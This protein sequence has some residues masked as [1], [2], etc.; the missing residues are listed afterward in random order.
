MKNKFFSIFV[1]FFI[2]Y[3]FLSCAN[4]QEQ[5]S[6]DVTEI[7]ILENG[8]KIIGSKR[9]EI[10]TNDGIVIKADTF[11]YKKNENIL[12]ANGKVIIKDT[13]NNYN[14][15]SDDITYNKNNEKISTKG[16]TKSEIYTRYIFNSND[17]TFFR[18]K[19]LINS[20]KKTTIIDNDEQTY[21]EL[22]NF[23]FSIENEILE[24]ENILVSLNYNLPQNDKLYF[25]NGIFNFKKKSFVANNI[26]I[27]LAKDIFNNLENDPRLKGVSA[28]SENNITTV[29]E[30]IFTS[31][32][33]DSDCPP[34]V[35][36]SKEIKHDKN[37]KQLI[38]KDAVLKVYNIPVLYFPKFFHPDPTVDRQ[39]G[40]LKPSF[41]NSNVL[42]SSINIP[43]YYVIS[44]NQDF[45]F[46]PTLFDD[47]VKM[48]QNEYRIKNKNSSLF[49]DFSYIDNF[50]S[51][52]T[53]KK[54]SISHIFANFDADLAWKNFTQSDLLVSIKKVSND[55]YLKIFDSNIYKN[56]VS[57]TNYDVLK[58]EAKLILNNENYN[59]TTGFQSYEDLNLSNTDR[60]Q[61][62]L[63][64][65]DFNRQ[66]FEN[67]YAGTINFSSSGSNDLNNTNN[68]RTK[69]VNDLNFQSPDF[70]SKNGFKSAYNIYFKNLNTIAKNDSIY[71]TNPQMELMSIFEL[72]TSF[73][74]I[75]QAKNS[76]T[77]FTPMASL[78]L[79]PGDM[80]DYSSSDRS[81]NVSS[82]F[83][84]NRLAIDDSFEEGKSLTLGFDYKR[85]KL[86]DINKFF[87]A[88]IA[89]VY[90]DK[91]EEFIPL[92]SGISDKDL[93][94]FGSISNNL[95]DF[96]DVSYDFIIDD[97][98]NSLKYNSL[99]TSI[100][101]KN[102]T[103]N[104]NFIEENEIIGD[105]N[106][107]ENNTTL[108]F[109]DANFLTFNTRRNKKIDLTEYYDLIYEYKNDCLI[110][111]IKY[112]K[113]YY[114]DR[115]LKPSENLL[116]S[117]TLSPL[118]SFEQKVD[119]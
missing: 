10:L 88:K 115:D 82:I 79:N 103:T 48:F 39:S 106:T 71:K 43:Y 3:F 119:Q 55:T 109:N 29:E 4:S 85:T 14:I 12:N 5:F 46:R 19:K 44:Q 28:K 77:Y 92:T 61:F 54:N 49:L 27:N 111:G 57:P 6:F 65:Y 100:A 50:K 41:N 58:S 52:L 72:N 7:E 89:T 99:K 22:K 34:W 94:I 64:Y 1:I 112:K 113:S 38:Y 24:G 84:I 56:E 9:G 53:N 68:L 102:F 105:T 15:Y 2:N 33:D 17:V 35:I 97:D 36:T 62:I 42:G 25:E 86:N 96:L 21:I 91:K 26:Q 73:P 31:C 37:K 23:N 59:F 78:R 66:I 98:L 60:Y 118:T 63:P 108:K 16:P 116:F 67:N 104:F 117:I 13:I 93:N 101:F 45:T 80:K 95:S 107:L 70:I 83:D 76:I 81:V 32:N 18:N 110:A 69:V 30:G 51:A 90:R 20:N 87:E 11:T 114:E 8:N 74:L 40:F 47:D 75:N